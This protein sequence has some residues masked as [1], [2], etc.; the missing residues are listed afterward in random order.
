[1]TKFIAILF[2]ISLLIVLPSYLLFIFGGWACVGI[3]LAF[4]VLEMAVEIFSLL[5]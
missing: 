4:K 2:L 5:S 3:F 1:M